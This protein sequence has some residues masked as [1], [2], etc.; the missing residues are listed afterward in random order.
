MTN[1]SESGL[2]PGVLTLYERS[3]QSGA[4]AYVGDARLGPLPAGEER[5]LSYAIDQKV[6]IDQE[7][8]NARTI[9]AGKIVDGVLDV[10]VTQRQTTL[11]TVTGAAR[12]SRTVL[13]EHPRYHGWT[14]IP[15]EGLAGDE[16]VE[17]TDSHYRLRV[18]LAAG[19]SKALSVS[20]EQPLYERHEMASMTKDQIAVF[21]ASRELS[22]AV[23]QAM[24]DLAGYQAALVDRENAERNLARQLNTV[25]EDQGRLRDNLRSVPG[26]SDLHQRYLGKM[27]EQE[28]QIDGL[29]IAID[30][31]H[32]A[33][34]EARQAVTD[35]VRGLNV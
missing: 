23:R 15:P 12:E 4:V 9:T 26:G 32:I 7:A 10:T 29:R 13:I 5:L 24:T 21:M 11:Y 27:A 34:L 14:L 1:G 2:P 31:A 30:D 8:R 19:E 18:E 17:T 25:I 35:F 22:P 28:D 33:A 16:P 6:R 3:A 20:M